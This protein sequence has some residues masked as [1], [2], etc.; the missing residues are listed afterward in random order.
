[1][2]DTED[3][4][5]K[6]KLDPR[7]DSE[8]VSAPSA[9]EDEDAIA[10]EEKNLDLE[11]RKKD[12]SGLK[13]VKEQLVEVYDAVVKGFEDKSEQNSVVDRAWDMYNC[14]LNE[15]QMYSGTSEIYVPLVRDAIEA[16]CTRFTNQ[17]FPQNGRYAD[18]VGQGDFPWD[19]TAILD[20]YVGKTKLKSVVVPALMREGDC[21]GQYSLFLDWTTKKRHTVRKIKKAEVVSEEGVDDPDADKFDDREYEEVTEEKPDVVVLDARNLCILPTNVDEVEDAEIV[22][23]AMWLTKAGI[24]KRI[25]DGVFDKDEGEALLENFDQT[26]SGNTQQ[27]DVEKKAANQAGVRSDSKGTKRCLIY[28]V[29]TKVKIKGEYRLM[30]IFFAG[31]DRVLSCKRLPFWNDK[32]PVVS[33][34]VLKVPGSIWG[35]SPS[36]AVEKLQYQANDAVNIGMDSAQYALLPIV[37]TDPADN[38][39]IGSM[40]LAQAAIWETNPKSTTFAQFPPLY[41]DALTIVGV[42]KDQIMQSLGVNPAMMPHASG[43][44]GKKP[45]QAQ[46]A[47]EQQVALESTSNVVSILEEGV[48]NEVLHWFYDMDYQFRTKAMTIQKFGQMGLQADLQ[49]VPLIEDSAHYVFKWNGTEANKSTQQVQQ[50]IAAMNVIRGIPPD[51]L[52][53]GMKIDISPILEH[54]AGVAFGPRLAPK[55]L[56]DQKHQQTLDPMVENELMA[57]GFPVPVHP[58]DNDA[59]HV[60]V[61]QKMIAIDQQGFVHQHIMEHLMQMKKK[62]TPPAPPGGG[63]A[64]GVPGG[65]GPGVAGTPRMG[66]QPGMPRPQ[67]PPGAVHQDQMPLAPPRR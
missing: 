62:S 15:N 60:Q 22:A 9:E 45:S 56:I 64:P 43:G 3:E 48:L 65:A 44:G 31:Q 53:P 67:Q 13:K 16:R 17:I 25:K 47:Q 11:D 52:P 49:Q 2:A 37:M 46:A 59:E 33:K 8:Q 7:P 66:A 35:K 24:K 21:S 6:T 40:I 1:M 5:K 18:V 41:K 54:M 12:Y 4:D 10:E 36:E 26:N 58:G 28:R 42:C 23:I 51:Q 61:H 20:H 34:P 32:I 29:W 63:G 14:V 38:P 39:K 55:V 50:M 19:I 57:S 27:P 30:D